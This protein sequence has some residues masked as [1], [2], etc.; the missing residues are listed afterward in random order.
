MVRSLLF[1]IWGRY[2][3]GHGFTLDST[4]RF[5]D[6]HFHRSRTWAM[7]SFNPSSGAFSYFWRQDSI[8]IVIQG[9]VGALRRAHLYMPY[10]YHSP[11]KSCTMFPPLMAPHSFVSVLALFLA[12]TVHVSAFDYSNTR[13]TLEQCVNKVYPQVQQWVCT[14]YGICN[15]NLCEY[16]RC[17]NWCGTRLTHD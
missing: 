6:I 4:G 17:D 7:T 9:C 3:L 13:G 1:A 5:R 16:V 11:A 15:A 2:A 8:I 14:F 12:L 10:P